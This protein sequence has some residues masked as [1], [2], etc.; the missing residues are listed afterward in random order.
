MCN[1]GFACPTSRAH[2]AQPVQAPTGA[3]NAHRHQ[4]GQP[5]SKSRSAARA[6][7]AVPALTNIPVRPGTRPAAPASV[8][9]PWGGALVLWAMVWLLLLWATSKSPPVD[10]AEQLAWVRS[11]EWG[12]HKHPPLPTALL[13]PLVKLFGLHEWVSYAAGAGVTVGALL[14]C[15][16]LLRQVCGTPMANLATLATLCVGY[17]TQ[18]LS[19]FNHDVVLLLCVSAAAWCCWQAFA[20][21]SGR[22]WLALGLVMGLG[23]LAKYQVA[24]AGVSVLACWVL[25]RGWRDAVH[26]RGLW[27]AVLLALLVLSPHALWVVSHD[28]LPLQYLRANGISTAMTVSQCSVGILRWIGN[29]FS[30]LAGPLLLGLGLWLRVRRRAV[31][32]STP[33]AAAGINARWFLLCWGVLPLLLIPLIALLMRGEL[34]MNWGTAYMPLTCAA[35]MA[36][37][38]RSHWQKVT[39]DEALWGFA[40]VQL[41]LV[42][43]LLATAPGHAPVLNQHR[44]RNFAS[45]HVADLIGPPARALL[46]YE[47]QIIAG[48]QR[49]ASALALRLAERPLVLIDGRF[50][51]SPWIPQDMHH[52]CGI[53]WVGDAGRAAP[54]DLDRHELGEGLWWAVERL[55]DDPD[56]C[57]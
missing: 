8:A 42:A 51:W 56:L 57:H 3:S 36:W 37:L 45:Q 20:L 17:Y 41:L 10:N 54:P 35:L 19:Y 32:V 14:V 53:L 24:L 47:V 16:A 30:Q 22:A 29:Q 34:H 31:P 39:R 33:A 52:V 12:Y 50:D 55:S 49:L 38:G 2:P 9:M 5:M 21:R 25:N 48:P 18:R 7:V 28:F 40:A 15:R 44:S 13:W 26:R 11:L 6:I 23:A 1:P 46:G 4:P 43:Y 27:Q